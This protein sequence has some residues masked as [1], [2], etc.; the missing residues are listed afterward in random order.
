MRNASEQI[1]SSYHLQMLVY[2]LNAVLIFWVVRSGDHDS[3]V[4]F[5]FKM[6]RQKHQHRSCNH[7]N[8][9]YCVLQ[10][11][12]RFDRRFIQRWGAMTGVVAYNDACFLA[13]YHGEFVDEIKDHHFIYLGRVLAP[14]VI[15]LEYCR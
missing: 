1:S 2:D 9:N 7:S 8:L 11:L 10:F 12:E 6:I 14:Y 15:K 13:E 3:Y 5:K 4:F